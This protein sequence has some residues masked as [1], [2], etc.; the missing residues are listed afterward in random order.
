[1]VSYNIDLSA[2]NMPDLRF[3]LPELQ[4][5]EKIN[6]ADY[7]LDRHIRSGWG[8]KV[9]ILYGDEKISYQELYVRTN[10]AANAFRQLGIGYKDAVI[11]RTANVPQF[12][13][14]AL[15]VHK[16]GGVLVPSMMLLKESTITFSANI[17][18][19]KVIVTSA[20]LLDEVESGRDKYETVEHIIVFGG[21]P[22]QIKARGFICY[23]DI[24]AGQSEE[25]TPILVDRLEPGYIGFTSGTTGEPKGCLH[26][27]VAPLCVAVTTDLALQYREDDVF[28]GTPPLAF[29]YGYC[30]L[31]LIPLYKGA[32]ISLIQGRA[33]PEACLQTV[34]KHRVTYFH[35]VPT[36]YNMILRE[37]KLNKLYDLSSVRVFLS[38]GAPLL[39]TTFEE[40]KRNYSHE[41]INIIG[42]HE[43]FGSYIGTWQ[44]P[45]KP[46]SVGNP[47]PGYEVVMLDDEGKPCPPNVPGNVGIKGPTG[48]IYLKRME[49]QAQAVLNGYSLSGDMGYFDEDN[50]IW[51]VSRSDD[52]I[53]S[54]GY[55]ISPEAVEDALIEH[56]QI[57][58]AGVIGVPHEIEGQRVKAFIVLNQ[59]VQPEEVLPFEQIMEFCRQRLAPY[60]I[61]KDI[62]IA[63]ELPKTETG[64]IKRGE[65]RKL[66][67]ER[68]S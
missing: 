68:R 25:I 50:Y 42:S 15:A 2:P 11:V 10:R 37:S 31:F 1:M 66:D 60:M 65:L 33:T 4:F 38:S 26:P 21:D 24:V 63:N 51:L 28:G 9:A 41:L 47:Y 22:A 14:I 62:E 58:E 67:T 8:N 40:W 32:T 64:K 46:G 5:S 48:I 23:E 43:T 6:V 53:K 59:G 57:F 19:A 3:S 13:E 44:R 12:H 30:H 36:M 55:R 27:Q 61:P 16:L 45:I 39:K 34:E 49:K 56:P 7:L 29:I 35:S 20:D 18:E 17:A 52:V 54:R